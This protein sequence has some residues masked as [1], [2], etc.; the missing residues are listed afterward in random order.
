LKS[1]TNQ[2]ELETIKNR[3]EECRDNFNVCR[4]EFFHE[5]EEDNMQALL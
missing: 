4:D 5:L 3:L 1:G 2:Q